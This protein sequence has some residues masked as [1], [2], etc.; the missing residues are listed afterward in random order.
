MRTSTCLLL[1]LFALGLAAAEPAEKKSAPV[2]KAEVEAV[3]AT[4]LTPEQKTAL[5]AIDARMVG[6]EAIIAK[7]DDVDYKADCD[8]SVADLKKRRTA[9]ETN[10]DQGLYEALMHSVITRY[11]IVALWL[12]PPRLPAPPGYVPVAKPAPKGKKSGSSDNSPGTY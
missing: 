11:Q 7:V 1:P 6:V 12:T 4:P 10:F 5:A 2:T 3:A 8:K 9:L